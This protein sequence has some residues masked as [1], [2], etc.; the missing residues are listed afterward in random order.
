MA[1]ICLVMDASVFCLEKLAN[2]SV[3]L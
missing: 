2:P 3:K 1:L